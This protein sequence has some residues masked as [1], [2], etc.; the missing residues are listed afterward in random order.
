MYLLIHIFLF[1]IGFA[2]SFI[3]SYVMVDIFSPR[4]TFLVRGSK[5][6][7]HHS[8]FALILMFFITIGVLIVLLIG[9]GDKIVLTSTDVLFFLGLIM[10]ALLHDVW[11]HS[12]E[13]NK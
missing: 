3:I 7:I 8:G 6:R 9:L 13:N 4:V 11:V 1:I 2:V 12:K 10:G 5:L